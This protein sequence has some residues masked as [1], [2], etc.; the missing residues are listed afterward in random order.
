[1]IYE[2]LKSISFMRSTSKAGSFYDLATVQLSCVLIAS[3]L[4]I[5]SEKF[6]CVLEEVRWFFLLRHAE[7][8]HPI[9]DNAIS[10][11][12]TSL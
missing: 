9:I 5:T 3:K 4:T 12:E 11:F 6:P 1:M 2:S 7:Y 8:N 10:I